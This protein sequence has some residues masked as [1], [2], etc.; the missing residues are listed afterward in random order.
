MAPKTKPGSTSASAP[1]ARELR[2]ALE[3]L[4]K[5]GKNTAEPITLG[6][7]LAVTAEPE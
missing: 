3:Q 5:N 6:E 4:V 1:V 2:A 7:L